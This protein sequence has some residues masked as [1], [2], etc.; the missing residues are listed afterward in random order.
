[1]FS[2]KYHKFIYLE[3]ICSKIY[4]DSFHILIKLEGLAIKLEAMLFKQKLEFE[5]PT[6]IHEIQERSCYQCFGIV[7]T[8]F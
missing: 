1:M 4:V 6:F 5:W 2:N 7:T 3:F 8:L